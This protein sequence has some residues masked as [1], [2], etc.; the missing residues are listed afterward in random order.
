MPSLLIS[1]LLCNCCTAVETERLN[2]VLII[3]DDQNDY[4]SA[5]SRVDAHPPSMDRLTKQ[6]ISFTHAY[7]ASPVCGPSRAALFSGLYPHHTGAYLNGAAP[8]LNSPVL[9]ATE[10]L[11]ELIQRGG[12]QTWGMG[13]LYHSKLPAGRE[14]RQW[15]NKARANGGLLCQCLASTASDRKFPAKPFAALATLLN[16]G[17]RIVQSAR[18]QEK[19][20]RRSSPDVLGTGGGSSDSC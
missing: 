12:Y 16:N 15:S 14:G 17:T 5:A 9:Q 19:T 10:T 4:F 8:W 11:L 6:A 2:I 20:R 13:K 7:C 3:T 1:I 18:F